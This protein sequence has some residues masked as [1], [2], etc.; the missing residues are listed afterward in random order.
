LQRRIGRLKVTPRMQAEVPVALVAFDVL[1]HAG[2]DIR[3]QTLDQR[4][5][6][7]E[8]LVFDAGSAALRLSPVVEFDEWGQLDEQRQQAR[9][10]NVEG[11]MLKR[12]D[13]AYG[14]GRPRGAWWKWKIQ[15]LSVDAV[16]IYAQPGHGRRASLLTD[17]TFGLWDE[18]VLVPVAK[19][20]SGLTD[21]EIRQVDAFV[22]A[23]TVERFGPVRVVEPRLVF[24]LHFDAVQRSTRHKSGF[25]V[26]FPRMHRWRSD[27]MPA[28]AD[29]LATLRALAIDT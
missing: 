3:S 11:L 14:V 26:R 10:H 4:R 18:G 5:A 13:S 7:L 12:R 24:E 9:Q 16:L 15:P 1:E 27:K 22:R 21:D 20:Y 2:G 6:I 17:Y 23:H 19:A 28:E 29:R 8:R 25:A